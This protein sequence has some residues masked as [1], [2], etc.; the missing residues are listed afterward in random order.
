MKGIT[1]TEKMDFCD[2]C[3]NGKDVWP[4]TCP[5]EDCCEKL[6]QYIKDKKD[7]ENRINS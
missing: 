4:F 7:K 6:K 2:T 3:Q 5:K 1:E